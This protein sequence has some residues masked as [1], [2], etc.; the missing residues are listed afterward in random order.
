MRS[1]PPSRAL[2]KCVLAA[3]AHDLGKNSDLEA[4]GQNA[5]GGGQPEVLLPAI[6]LP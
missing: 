3:K 5:L 4:Q 6:A 1:A 2:L